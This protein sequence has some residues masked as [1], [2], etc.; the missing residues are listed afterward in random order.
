M[1][2]C[3]SIPHSS[4]L[5]L[6]YQFDKFQFSFNKLDTKGNPRSVVFWTSIFH[7]SFACPYSYNEFIDQ[8]VHPVTT[9]LTGN[10]P[11]RISDEIK[12]ILQLSKQYKVGDQY[13]YHNHIEIRIYGCE[14]PPFRLPK[15]VPMRLF[16]LEYYRQM[17]NSDHIHFTKAKKKSTTEN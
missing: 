10:P 1:K 15:Y 13:L 2:K 3:S 17:I 7:H 8:F 4:H 9:M 11:P 5:I 12:R 14:I 6:Y 16:A